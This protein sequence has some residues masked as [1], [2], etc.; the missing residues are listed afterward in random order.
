M[1]KALLAAK[2]TV[3]TAVSVAAVTSPAQCLT[4][5]PGR[6]ALCRWPRKQRAAARAAD[7]RRSGC[8]PNVDAARG[9]GAASH[10]R[11][12]IRFSSADATARSCQG[13]ESGRR[14]TPRGAQGESRRA[15]QAFGGLLLHSPWLD[16]VCWLQTPLTLAC[17]AG[18]ADVAIFLIE[19]KADVTRLCKNE[20]NALAAQSL[21]C[22]VSCVCSRCCIARRGIPRL[23]WS[24]RLSRRAV[25]ST[26]SIIGNRCDQIGWGRSLNHRDAD[27]SDACLRKRAAG[28]C[29]GAVG[30]QGRLD[31]SPFERRLGEL[32]RLRRNG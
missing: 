3:Q 6:A 9:I 16:P 4:S 5:Y 8:Q 23:S 27:S 10:C 1:I 13:R 28:D 22:V 20:V 25:M 26:L 30:A 17:D 24:K 32:W 21:L 15:E 14:E 18:A 31:R 11:R 2:A 7:A 19:S 29:E 12:A